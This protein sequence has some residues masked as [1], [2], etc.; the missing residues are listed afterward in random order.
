M[1][2]YLQLIKTL[3]TSGKRQQNR[4]GVATIGAPGQML[5]YD[6]KDGFPAIT[7]RRLAFKTGVGELVAFLRAESSAAGFRALGCKVWDQ[8]ANENGQWLANPYREGHDHLGDIYGVQWRKWKAYKEIPLIQA[9]QLEHALAKGFVQISERVVNDQPVAILFKEIDQVRECLDKIMYTPED[10][11]ILFHGWNPAALDAVAL[12]S[13]HLLY[14]FTPNVADKE[15]SLTL[16]IRSN[17]IGLGNP[18]NTSEAACL[19]A[20]FGRLTGYTPRFLNIMIADAHIY[21]NQLDML[22]EQLT[23]EP[24][25]L[26]RLKIADRVPAFAETGVYE[27]QWLDLI[28]PDDF[29]LQNYT[30]EA[31]LT[32]PMAV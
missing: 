18:L 20:L 25:A 22:Q 28:E 17:D 4:T 27:P 24:H 11:R 13:C 1:K 26:P 16:Y 10:R 15:L 29:I 19:L 2:Q 5:K 23:R 21:E 3:L 12:P 7:T 6:L 32:A 8:N 9:A 31:P 30:H 14:Q